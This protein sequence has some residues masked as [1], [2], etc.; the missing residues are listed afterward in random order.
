[1]YSYC[2]FIETGKEPALKAGLQDILPDSVVLVP[3]YTYH[4]YTGSGQWIDQRRPL[5]PGYLFLF[6]PYQLDVS[7]VWEARPLGIIRFLRNNA[8]GTYELEG[9]DLAFAELIWSCQGELGATPVVT[10][11]TLFAFKDPM[12]GKAEARII[13]VDRRQGNML[14][15][16]KLDG[17]TS[18][19]WMKYT[20]AEP[21]EPKTGEEIIREVE[22]VD[23]PVWAMR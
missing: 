11:N 12:F 3:S 19:V 1:M 20:L 21:A 10:N 18:R 9:S 14:V 7:V 8:N 6:L 15:E 5:F 4:L 17:K 16:F 13:K 23:D 2:L 22:S